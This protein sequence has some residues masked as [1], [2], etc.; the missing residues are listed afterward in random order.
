MVLLCRGMQPTGTGVHVHKHSAA[1]A[2]L[3]YDTLGL[4]L[5]YTYTLSHAYIIS[6]MDLKPFK[7]THN[8]EATSHAAPPNNPH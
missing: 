2:D 7:S 8:A 4:N 3:M 6:E 1:R 5:V